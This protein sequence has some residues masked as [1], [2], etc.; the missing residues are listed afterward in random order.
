MG[1][2]IFSADPLPHLSFSRSLWG[3]EPLTS[4]TV[5]G[6][7]AILWLVSALSG[8]HFDYDKDKGEQ[9]VQSLIITVAPSADKHL[10]TP[11]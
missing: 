8:Q 3:L 2:K 10:P 7:N 9:I 4:T 11:R 1:E 5:A 6:Y